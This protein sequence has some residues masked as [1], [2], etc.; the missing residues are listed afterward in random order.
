MTRYNVLIP[1]PVE[2]ADEVLSEMSRQIIPHYGEEWGYF[3]NEILCLLKSVF[4]TSGDVFTLVGSGTAGVEATIA[5]TVS[6]QDKILVL[7]NGFFGDRLTDIARSHTAK[8]V[9]KRFPLDAPLPCDELERTLKEDRSLR[10]VAAVHCETVSGIVNPIKELAEVCREAEALFIV[11]AISTLGGIDLHMDEW[12]IDICVSASQ[13]CLG[14]PPGL[15]LVAVSNRALKHMQQRKTSGWY[16]NLRTWKDA[17]E[18]GKNWKLSPVT[19]A[20][21]T[22]MGLRKGLEQLA[23]EG[24]LTRFERCENVAR[25]TRSGLTDLGFDVF[26]PQE[27][28]SPTVTVARGQPTLPAEEVVIGLKKGHKILVAGGAGELAGQ[29]F[30][31]GHMGIQATVQRI[32][33]LLYALG[34]LLD[35]RLPPSFLDRKRP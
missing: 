5:S 33:A 17:M 14:G 25:F 1:G 22:L 20:T 9:V 35:E 30:R 16:L 24:L 34:S 8:A 29:V 13:K 21:P 6:P 26:A 18:A 32:E 7:S 12:N 3:Y 11:D 28:A 31:I 2:V 10:I 15:A 23:S 4:K 19:L 27:F